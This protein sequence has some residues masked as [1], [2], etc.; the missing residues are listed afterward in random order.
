M[1]LS[2][3]NKLDLTNQIDFVTHSLDV[4]LIATRCTGDFLLGLYDYDLFFIEAHFNPENDLIFAI[5]GISFDHPHVDLYIDQMVQV[6]QYGE[7]Q[8]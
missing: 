2:G 1:T 4:F 6:E 3:F 8:Y 5:D 7:Y